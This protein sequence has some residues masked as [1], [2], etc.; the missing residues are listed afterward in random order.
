MSSLGYPTTAAQALDSPDGL[1]AREVYLDAVEALAET[2]D[3]L[4]E[5]MCGDCAAHAMS[6]AFLLVRTVTTHPAHSP[7]ETTDLAARF[8]AWDARIAAQDAHLIEG[9]G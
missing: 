6:E 5:G 1:A 7:H 2:L 4:D 8:F 3:W 9:V